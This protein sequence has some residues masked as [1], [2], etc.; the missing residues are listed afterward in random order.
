MKEKSLEQKLRREAKRQG[1]AMHKS[2]ASYSGDN[3]DGYMIAD[4]NNNIVAGE[5]YNLSLEDVEKFLKE[6]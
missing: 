1:Y 6:E 5:K 3:Q 4:L 2:R